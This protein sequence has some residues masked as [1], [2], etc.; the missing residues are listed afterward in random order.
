LGFQRVEGGGKAGVLVPEFCVQT[1][2]VAY[3]LV[4]FHV[5]QKGY[6]KWF[7]VHQKIRMI[8]QAGHVAYKLVMMANYL[9]LSLVYRTGRD[10]STNSNHDKTTELAETICPPTAG[11]VGRDL[12]TN[13]NHDKTSW[14]SPSLTEIGLNCPD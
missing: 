13:S 14:P 12:S 6:G 7:V 1:G 3:K 5:A 2:H 9:F 8:R 4:M 11:H 10:L